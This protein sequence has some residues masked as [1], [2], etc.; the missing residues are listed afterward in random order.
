MTKEN[1]NRSH[2]VRC[3]IVCNTGKPFCR[4]CLQCVNPDETHCNICDCCHNDIDV[5]Y[6]D[7]CKDCYCY[8]D[9]GSK[10]CDCK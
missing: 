8:N 5:W 7:K 3:R 1:T 9:D 2:C 6:C 10:E 4:T